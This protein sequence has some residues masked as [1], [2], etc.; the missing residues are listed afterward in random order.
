M[1]AFMRAMSAK[2]G[3]AADWASLHRWSVERREVFW[4]E[5]LALSGAPLPMDD[6]R[7]VVGEGLLGT[8][9]FPGVLLNYAAHLMRHR[10]DRPAIVA[11]DERGRT[12]RL[13]H[14]DVRAARSISFE[15]GWMKAIGWSGSCRT[16]PRR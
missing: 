10:D 1:H 6:G 8:R 5:M 16:S 12:R 3:F 2:H 15:S 9:W 11:E 4:R 7:T 14:H 13:T